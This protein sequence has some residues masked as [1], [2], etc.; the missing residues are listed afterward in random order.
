MLKIAVKHDAVPMIL[1]TLVR[2]AELLT[3]HGDKERAAEIV[4]LVQCYPLRQTL[5]RRAI[6]LFNHLEADLNPRTIAHARAMTDRITLDDMV[7]TI[8][9]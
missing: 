5:Q 4:T 6:T 1:E 2:V 9:V 7:E 3:Q 8:L